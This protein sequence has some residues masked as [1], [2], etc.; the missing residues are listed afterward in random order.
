MIVVITQ[1]VAVA[2]VLRTLEFSG[3][4]EGLPTKCMV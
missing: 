4:G 2:L 1:L 3:P